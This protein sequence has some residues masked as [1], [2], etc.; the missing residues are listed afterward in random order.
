MIRFLA[1]RAALTYRAQNKAGW[2]SPRVASAT[3]GFFLCRRRFN[4]ALR[5]IIFALRDRVTQPLLA[6]MQA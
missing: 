4:C 1:F 2:N 3:R 6:R 5:R